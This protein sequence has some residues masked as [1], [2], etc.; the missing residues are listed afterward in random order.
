MIN[1]LIKCFWIIQFSFLTITALNAIEF[2][3]VFIWGHKLHTHT[4]SYVHYGF[5]K[6]FVHLGFKTFWLDNEDDLS[7]YDFSKSLFITEGQ[8]DDKMPIRAD[9]FYIV[10]N[11]RNGQKYTNTIKS[12]HYINLY[13][14]HDLYE[15]YPTQ[16]DQLVFADFNTGSIAIPWATD[17]LPNEIEANKLKIKNMCKKRKLWWIGSIGGGWAGNIDQLKPFIKACTE[18]NIE[19]IQKINVSSEENALLIQESFLAPAIVGGW[20][21]EHDYVPCRVF[22][23]ISYGCT[24]MTNS[25]KAHELFEQRLIYNADTYQLFYDSLKSNT[26]LSEDNILY[27]MDLVKNKHTYIN[28]I[29]TLLTF[30]D[31]YI[32]KQLDSNNQ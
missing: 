29:N 8:V 28:R 30:F 14:Y 13:Q 12:K 7:N 26:A 6:A 27:L 23:N 21:F 11:C 16:L 32:R 1:K 9:S 4:H 2:D 10:H 25:K 20:Q 3:K 15:K 5:Y 24:V 22:K 17:L 31:E 18:N 19:F